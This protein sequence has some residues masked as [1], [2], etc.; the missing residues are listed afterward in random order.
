[1]GSTEC[2]YYLMFMK[3]IAYEVVEILD[4]DNVGEGVE[5]YS[6][7]DMNDIHEQ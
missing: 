4:N 6:D 1:M 2:D 7:A 3:E 5:E